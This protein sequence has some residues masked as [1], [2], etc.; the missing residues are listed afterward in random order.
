MLADV[1][2][3]PEQVVGGYL[4]TIP[5]LSTRGVVDD[6]ESDELLDDLEGLLSDES[7]TRFIGL[8]IR[9]GRWLWREAK[10]R[11]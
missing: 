10:K 3:P 1:A 4:S 2:E 6:G 9:V 8:P 7:Q 5:P 11:F